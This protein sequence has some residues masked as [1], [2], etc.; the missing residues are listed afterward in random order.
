MAR[1]DLIQG[2][3]TANA[4]TYSTASIA[5]GSNRVALAFV[6]NVRAAPGAAIEPTAQ[7]NGLTWKSVGRFRLPLR[8]T[9]VSLASAR[10]ERR[11]LQVRCRKS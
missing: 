2:N 5:P 1:T 10:P 8:R 6:M 3:N 9:A 11:R 4:S 7:G